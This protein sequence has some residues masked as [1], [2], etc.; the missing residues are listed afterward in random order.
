MIEG[1][2]TNKYCKTYRT[3]ET[4]PLVNVDDGAHYALL[5]PQHHGT[6]GTCFRGVNLTKQGQ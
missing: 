5:V 4:E 3:I 2:S 1:E 6:L